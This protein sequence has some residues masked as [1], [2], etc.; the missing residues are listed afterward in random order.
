MKAYLVTTGLLFGAMAL[1]HVWR[2][3]V[4]WPRSG[5]S[6][7]FLLGMGTLILLPGLFAWWAWHLLRN[8]AVEMQ[9]VPKKD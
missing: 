6:A 1:V 8:R 3:I 9:Q 4:E 5:V 2:A 7:L